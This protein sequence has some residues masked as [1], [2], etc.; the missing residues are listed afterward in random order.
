MGAAQDPELL[1]R[2]V[3]NPGRLVLGPTST[4]SA[5]PY[6]GV[7]LGFFRDGEVVWHVEYNRNRDPASGRTSEI[8][9]EG[10]EFPEIYCLIEGP[11]WDEDITLAAFQRALQASGLSFSQPTEARP[12][13]TN[14]PTVV[15]A[16]P[17][18]LMAAE[19]PA[20]RSV[21]MRRPVLTLSIRQ[22]TAIA[23]TLKAGLPLLFTPTPDSSG[24]DDWQ[25]ARLE[26]ITL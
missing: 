23:Q 13:G 20:Q 11:S 9:R 1:A 16:C 22:A 4:T 17:P 6:G 14:M 8:N 12:G 2:A 26:N 10:V 18:I 24:D 19:D 21:Y 25:C 15:V 5:F 7:N 3:N